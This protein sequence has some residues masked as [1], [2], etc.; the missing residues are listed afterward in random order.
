MESI[1]TQK[2]RLA[3]AFTN[4]AELTSKQ[5]R[6]QFKIASPTKV[7]SQLR[8]EDGM[9]IYLNQRTD[10]KGRTTQKYRLGTPSRSIIAAGYRAASLGL[11]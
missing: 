7:V 4:G 9:S 2:Q 1:M 11:V 3:S 6:S 8:L 10:S 5:I